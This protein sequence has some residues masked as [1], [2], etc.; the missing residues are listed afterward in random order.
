MLN[1]QNF[2]KL[3]S[4]SQTLGNKPVFLFLSFLFCFTSGS[5]Q[6]NLVPNG[7]FEEYYWCP[8]GLGDL[9][10]KDWSSPTGAT[11]DYYNVCN[12]FEVGI[13][14]NFSGNQYPNS[15]SGYAGFVYGGF[16][17]L[18]LNAR[19]YLKVKLK[20]TLMKNEIYE[21]SLFLSLSE[22]SRFSSKNIQLAFTEYSIFESI[23]TTITSINDF[24]S[25]EIKGNGDTLNWMSCHR[26]YKANGDEN[27]LI[28]GLFVNDENAEYQ[29]FNA[30]NKAFSYYY[31][32]DVV[33]EKFDIS[34]IPNV[35]TPN[36]DGINDTWNFEFVAN[37]KVEIINRWGG[38]LYSE[39]LK[40]ENFNWNGNTNKG[41]IC[42]TGTYFYRISL[43][44][45]IKTGFI[46]LIR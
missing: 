36:N 20:E 16:T 31:I 22:T 9:S 44:D 40:N 46:Q 21:I 14:N 19:E 3:F 30:Q 25:L 1:K 4:L 26:Y 17:S 33:I 45:F 32:D 6:E 34:S 8:V 13:P 7:S 15:G 43:N 28:I 42:E 39:I 37:A 10:L 12:S 2:Q 24:F 29:L 27:Y 38:V 11:P 41:L 23:G 18:Q 35:L 5:A